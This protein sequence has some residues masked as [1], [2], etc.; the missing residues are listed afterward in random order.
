M[1]PLLVL[2]GIGAMLGAIGCGA[3]DGVDE[4][5]GR[6]IRRGLFDGDSAFAIDGAR[7]FQYGDLHVDG[8]EGGMM[9]R[10]RTTEPALEWL[11][12]RWSLRHRALEELERLIPPAVPP[13]PSW[14]RP[15]AVRRGAVYV[16]PVDS[17]EGFERTLLFVHDRDERALFVLDH[18]L[19]VRS[20]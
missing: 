20:L 9:Y 8:L 10:F 1:G 11:I 14:W 5:A 17:S 2:V 4:R 3:T 12:A 19:T 15:D 16:A 6:L 7:A 13:G 18:I